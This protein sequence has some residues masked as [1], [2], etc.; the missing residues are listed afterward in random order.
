MGTT[1]NLP[2]AAQLSTIPATVQW[3]SGQNFDGYVWMGLV[4]PNGYSQPTVVNSYIIQQF[5]V[6][7]KVPIV[8][9]AID[10]TTGVFWNSDIDPPGTQY[11]A[12]Y[13]D[14]NNALIAP[15]S[16]TAMPFSIGGSVATLTVPT[17]PQP[18][19]SAANPVPQVSSF[20]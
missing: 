5:P 3:Q 20:P 12:Y 19:Y 16:G 2:R 1:P 10:N 9:G 13:M 15:T 4:L 18:V 8:N 6:F 7:T 14:N 11:V 17:L